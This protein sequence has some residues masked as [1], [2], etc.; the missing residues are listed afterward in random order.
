MH[1]NSIVAPEGLPF[2]LTNELTKE[3]LISVIKQLGKKPYAL[4]P[5]MEGKF[6]VWTD[7]KLAKEIM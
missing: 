7:G 2:Q 5:T 6:V 1:P 4:T 3:E